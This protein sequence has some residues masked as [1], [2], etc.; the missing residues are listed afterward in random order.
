MEEW[1]LSYALLVGIPKSGQQ[2]N[3]PSTPDFQGPDFLKVSILPGTLAL[4]TQNP[5]IERFLESRRSK[6]TSVTQWNVVLTRKSRDRNSEAAFTMP[7]WGWDVLGSCLHWIESHPAWI[8]K[9]TAWQTHSKWASRKQY[10]HVQYQSP[11][12]PERA[13]LGLQPSHN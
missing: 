10:K 4:A 11:P 1:K 8:Q 9:T 13:K 5:E 12:A 6:P 7:V 3:P 2:K